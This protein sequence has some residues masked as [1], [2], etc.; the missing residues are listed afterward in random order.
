MFSLSPLHQAAGLA[1][2]QGDNW[3]CTMLSDPRKQFPHDRNYS[4]TNQVSG[5]RFQHYLFVWLPCHKPAKLPLGGFAA[6]GF[7]VVHIHS[8]PC[9]CPCASGTVPTF[10]G[11]RDLCE[12]GN[13]STTATGFDILY[14][15]DPPWDGQGCG[16][17]PC[18]QWSSPSGVTAPWF[19][20]F[21]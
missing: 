5:F 18:C 1:S 20:N 7:K 19:C 17:P 8:C 10:I 14:A 9:S 2:R 15:S 11:N 21:L 12:S 6:G 3:I 13:P 4:H 16:S